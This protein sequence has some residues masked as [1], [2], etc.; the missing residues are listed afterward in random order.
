MKY[1]LLQPAHQLVRSHVDCAGLCTQDTHCVVFGFSPG[2]RECVLAGVPP[3]LL[4]LTPVREISRADT[5][6]YYEENGCTDTDAINLKPL[7]KC[8]EKLA[9]RGYSNWLTYSAECKAA[10]PDNRLLELST[11][12]DFD[13]AVAVVLA[14]DF[15]PLGKLCVGAKGKSLGIASYIMHWVTSSLPVNETLW[16]NVAMPTRREEDEEEEDGDDELDIEEETAAVD[17]CAYLE[18]TDAEV[19]FRMDECAATWSGN[20][21]ALCDRQM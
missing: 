5:L 19:F 4:S 14:S 3:S 9:A 20:V 1:S 2:Y 16:D 8:V 7:G 15:F 13:Y 18:K 12:A 10:N 17:M 11:A 21:S 6:Y